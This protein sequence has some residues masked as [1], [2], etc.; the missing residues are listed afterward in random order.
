M[1]INKKILSSLVTTILIVS[2]LTLPAPYVEATKDIDLI[3]LLSPD[4][5]PIGVSVTVNGTTDKKINEYPVKIYWSGSTTEPTPETTEYGYDYGVPEDL[6]WTLLAEV[7]SP[8][9]PTVS[10][11]T[12][13]VA[14]TVPHVA[15][16]DTY[17]IVAWQ[18]EDN[19]TKLDDGEWDCAGF[20]VVEGIYPSSG[21]VGD[22]VVVGGWATPG[23]LVLVYWDYVKDENKL[24]ETY[25]KGDGS[26]SITITI[27]E[28]PYE[29]STH[30]II[31]KDGETGASLFSKPVTIIPE[32]TLD[33]STTLPGKTVTVEGTGFAAEQNI[34]LTLSNSTH[35]WTSEKNLTVTPETIPTDVNGSFSCSFK[36]PSGLDYM[37]YNVTATD[38]D[39]NSAKATL[40][41]GAT[42][43]LSPE[44][45]PTGTIVS[46][47]GDGWDTVSAGTEVT[48]LIQNDDGL[49]MTC[50][51]VDTIKVTST[52]TFEGE[53]IIPTVDVGTYTIN[54]TAGGISGTEEFEV[55]GTT[56]ITL[57]PTSGAPDSSVTVQGVNFTAQ[58]N[59]EVTIDFGPIEEVATATTNSTGGFKTTVTVPPL[60]PSV[61]PYNVTAVDENG[62]NATAEFRVALTTLAIS[63]S[64]GPTGTE[65]LILGGGFT[66]GAEFNVTIDYAGG[67]LLVNG[68][69]TINATTGNIPDQFKAYIPTVPVGTYTITV[70]DEDGVTATATFE[71]TKRTE[72]VLTPSSAPQG[73][74]VTIELNY[75]TAYN[76]TSIDLRIYNVTAEGEIYWRPKLEDAV[77]TGNF[78]ASPGFEAV[79]T[80]ETGSFKATFVVPASFALGDYYIN[81]TDEYGLWA[82]TTFSVVEPEVIVYTGSDTYMPGDTVAFFAKC[83]F[84]YEN[85]TINL[86]TPDN[87]KI[88][89]DDLDI[90]TKLGDYY[91][92]TVTYIL[93]SDAKLDT[94]FWNTT[95]GGKTVNGTFTVVEKPTTATLSERV[96]ALEE[97]VATLTGIVEDLSD[98]VESQAADIN[99]LRQAVSDLSDAVSTLR[100]DVS[101]VASA[102]SNVATAVQS[103]Q[104][105]SEAASEA[106]SAAQSTA[107]GIQTAVYG[108]VIL[109]L[110]AAVAAIMS[111]VILQRKIA[112]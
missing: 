16:E 20:K 94:W 57:S 9:D 56:S 109:S 75:F 37:D 17:Y 33:P 8:A 86:Y 102:V 11:Y 51:L 54:A 101:N 67:T 27:P 82:N 55:T 83:T 62:L 10:N 60:T 81:A 19:D 77:G 63:P 71:V 110:I 28:A 2:I 31:V 14:V 43:T 65:V 21:S 18:D 95:I 74:N 91:T 42:I 25:A 41:I 107:A 100:T 58:A 53:F 59:V 85:Q 68:T 98:M 80:N 24:G 111:I 30:Y 40:T 112:G 15:E 92:G 78:S 99:T 52:G 105:A 93:P 22:E 5:G 13:E 32:I 89:I 3:N 70:M 7:E 50:P 66:P 45:G 29:S 48:V 39:G 4:E 88:E 79:I 35:L 49:N 47:T 108:A 38:E 103:A 104:T 44:E 1:Q 106:A 26:F 69:G 34:T 73:Y 46:I 87:F 23:G 84:E 76:K 90:V 97:D 72:I 61:T 12:Y 96:S 6:G 64:R 36:V